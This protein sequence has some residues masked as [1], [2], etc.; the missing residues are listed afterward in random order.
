MQTEKTLALAQSDLFQG[1]TSEDI[2]ELERITTLLTCATGHILYRPGETGSALFL[3]KEG[4]IHLYHLS[5]DGRKLLIA[6]LEAGASLGETSL[7]GQ[8]VYDSFAE[9]TTPSRIYVLSTHELEQLIAHKPSLAHALLQK[10][11]Q[12]LISLESQLVDTTFKSVSARLATLLLHL[13]EADPQH[14][15]V[16]GFSHEALAD[17]LGVYRETVSAALRELKEDGVI[18]LGR[19][20][21]TIRQPA[22]L[23]AIAESARKSNHG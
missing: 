14:C 10:L 11:G 23:T 16:R 21:V 2:D 19:K 15:V 22:Q 20:R 8:R 3:L 6:S 13:A 9:A 18:E 4:N 7:T 12:R 17:R 5:T 1:L